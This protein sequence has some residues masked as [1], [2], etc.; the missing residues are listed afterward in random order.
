MSEWDGIEG[1]EAWGAKLQALL[2]EGSRI[3]DGDQDARRKLSDRL[4]EFVVR[5]RPNEPRILAL[6]DIAGKAAIDLLERNIDERLRSIVARNVELAQVS[7]RF[8][9]GADALGRTAAQLRLERVTKT[10]D[11]LNDSVAKMKDLA[12][13]LKGASDKDLAKAIDKAMVAAQ[14]VRDLL[15]RK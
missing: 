13:T 9:E 10:L 4:T 5:S 1:F 11:S 8:E 14:G 12:L 15:E 7:K 3:A 6:D 2:N